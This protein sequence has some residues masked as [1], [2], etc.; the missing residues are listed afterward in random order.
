MAD[1]FLAKWAGKS[2][3]ELVKN[4]EKASDGSA[5][6]DSFLASLAEPS[7][8]SEGGDASEVEEQGVY[9]ESEV[10][11]VKV[12]ISTLEPEP[13]Q[14]IPNAADII[15]V[16]PNTQIQQQELADAPQK[17]SGSA[18]VPAAAEQIQQQELADAPQKSSGSTAVPA[19]AEAQ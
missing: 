16:D 5:A 6:I 18:A 9:V 17:S 12:E 15:L 8:S 1:E 14:V 4:E 7:P 11:Q 3:S 10:V 19:A 13:P 2:F